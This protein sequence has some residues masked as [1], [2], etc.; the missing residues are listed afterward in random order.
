MPASSFAISTRD[1][2]GTSVN[3]ISDVRC[4]H[5]EVTSRMPT[6]GPRSESGA[7]ATTTNSRSVRSRSSMNRPASDDDGDREQ[8][9]DEQQPEP[10]A[11]VGHL[12]QL[13][14]A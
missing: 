10:G 1:R 3:V 13:D 8:R 2:W 12:A 7:V 4:D 5:S 11:R 6:T 14:A 9:R